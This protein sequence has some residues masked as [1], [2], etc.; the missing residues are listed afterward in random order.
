MGTQ[1]WV[2]SEAFKRKAVEHVTSSDLQ[3]ETARELGLQETVF[4]RWVR[5]IASQ[6]AGPFPQ[7][8]APSPTDSFDE[9]V[10]L[11]REKQRLRKGY[12]ILKCRPHLGRSS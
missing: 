12:D 11:R 6:A 2:F 9:N 7:I 5:D 4:C 3:H 10:R 1:S 8:A